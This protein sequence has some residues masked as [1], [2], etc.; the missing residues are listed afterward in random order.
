MY[1]AE[2]MT[3]VSL[4]DMYDIYL[5]GFVRDICPC[6]SQ[7]ITIPINKRNTNINARDM[8][9]VQSKKRNSTT[10][11]F[12]TT[13]IAPSAIRESIK[14]S[15]KFICTKLK[16]YIEQKTMTY[17]CID[18]GLSRAHGRGV[19]QTYLEPIVEREC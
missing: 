14:I 7:P 18:S 5:S 10:S 15:F 4:P 12:C 3:F 1:L 11:T 9:I 19:L 17:Y 16:E 6:S 13:N 2:N 8:D